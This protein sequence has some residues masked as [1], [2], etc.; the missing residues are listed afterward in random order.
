MKARQNCRKGVRH[1]TVKTRKSVAHKC[2]NTQEFIK[3]NEHWRFVQWV[4]SFKKKK[5]FVLKKMIIEWNTN[6]R[7]SHLAFACVKESVR[8]RDMG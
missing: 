2:I 8:T 1:P 3:S 4:M 6:D 7:F 5:G